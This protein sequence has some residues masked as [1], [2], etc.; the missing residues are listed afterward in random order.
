VWAEAY[1]L[2]IAD[3]EGFIGEPPQVPGLV[4]KRCFRAYVERK[5][6][7][8]NYGHAAAA[9]LGHLAGKRFI[10]ECMADAAIRSEIEPAMRESGEAL[11]RRYPAEF[12]AAAQEEHIQDLL[13]RFHNRALGDTVFRVGRDL[14]RKLAPGD[15][16][17]GT[18]RLLQSEG[19]SLDRV[20]HIIAAALRFSAADENGK[21]LPEDEDVLTEVARQGPEK[22][23]VSLCGLDAVSD[24]DIIANISRRYTAL[25]GAG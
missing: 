4:L 20:C 5:L 3:G 15:R 22:V 10:W 25:S 16:C 2:I 14:R 8:H 13:R 11:R 9:Y 18:L 19:L 1:N 21:R 12:S 17:L 7:I 6:Y 23:L 24:R